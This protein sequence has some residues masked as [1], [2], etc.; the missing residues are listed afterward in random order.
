MKRKEDL[1]ILKTRLS[2][3]EGLG[4][5]L[6]KM[7]F[8][9]IKVSDI[10]EKAMVNRST[11]YAHFSDKYELFH[12]YVNDLKESLVEELKKNKQL[13]NS[14]EY[15][16]EMLHLF[17]T[18]IEDKKD[19]YFSILIHNKNSII[20]DMIYD[21]FTLD[22]ERRLEQNEK[23]IV[24]I[25]I[26]SKFYLGAVFSVSTEWLADRTKYTKEEMIHYLEILIP[27]NLETHS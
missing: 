9:E 5:L 11:F 12:S 23:T 20:M 1:R 14:R 8:E 24:P 17:F 7:P 19:A 4:S 10:C 25:N 21:A 6:E 16:L 18:H 3:Y 26:V 15:Y 2:L 27:D 22:L 13:T